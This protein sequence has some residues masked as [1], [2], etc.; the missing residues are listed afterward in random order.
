MSLDTLVYSPLSLVLSAGG[1]LDKLP[2]LRSPRL[3]RAKTKQ[4][5]NAWRP[6]GHLAASLNTLA[7]RRGLASP[8][9]T[10]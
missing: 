10:R 9:S 3:N 1:H 2:G 7:G 4:D 5:R 8:G 6:R